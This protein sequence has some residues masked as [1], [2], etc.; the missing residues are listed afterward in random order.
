MKATQRAGC[1]WA[2]DPGPQ[3]DESREPSTPGMASAGSRGEAARR[4]RAPERGGATRPRVTRPRVAC[5]HPWSFAGSGGRAGLRFAAGLVLL[6]GLM[7][8]AAPSQAQV[9]RSFGSRFTFNGSGSIT[10]TGNTVM[11]PTNMSGSDNNDNKTMIYT[12]VDAD[13]STFSSSTAT[14]N[15]PAGAVVQWAGL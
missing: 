2:C 4:M 6:G 15:L 5:S 7:T 14:L 11:V 12:D 13:A 8:F 3:G 10:M 9:A 1:A